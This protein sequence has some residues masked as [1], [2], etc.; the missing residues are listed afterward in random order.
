MDVAKEDMQTVGVT[1]QDAK[2]RVRWRKVIHCG[3]SSQENKKEDKR[4]V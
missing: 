2:D 4:L 1:E 3:G